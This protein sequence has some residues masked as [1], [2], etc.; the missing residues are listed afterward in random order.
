[1]GIGSVVCA[2]VEAVHVL[3]CAMLSWRQLNVELS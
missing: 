2:S 3:C 1:M